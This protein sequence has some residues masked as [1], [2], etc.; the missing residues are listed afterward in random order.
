[1]PRYTCPYAANHP[2][3]ARGT[4]GSSP[5]H[6]SFPQYG[7]RIC[8]QTLSRISERKKE[9]SCEDRP[10]LN[11]GASTLTVMPR[12]YAKEGSDFA[13]SAMVSIRHVILL[14]IPPRLKGKL[15]DEQFTRLTKKQTYSFT[16][17]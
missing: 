14:S 3:L 6:F 7:T 5:E 16:V 10:G 12:N 8:F 13:N 1:M 17:E 4:L 2:H 11:P 9:K 15:F